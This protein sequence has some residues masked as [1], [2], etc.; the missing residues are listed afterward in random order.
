[1]LAR[2]QAR[3][4]LRDEIE[5]ARKENGCEKVQLIWLDV[6]LSLLGDVQRSVGEVKK[7]LDEDGAGLDGACL[8][9]GYAPLGGA[10]CKRVLCS[11]P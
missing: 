10:K 4:R 5:A 6:E 2:A 8:S 1:M 3:E 9:M 7:Q 11:P